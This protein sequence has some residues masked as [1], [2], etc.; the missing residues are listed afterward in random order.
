MGR[1]V[2]RGILNSA[3]GVSDKDNSSEAQARCR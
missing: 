2:I 1:G 3:S